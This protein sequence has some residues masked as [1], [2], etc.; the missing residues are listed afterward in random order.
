MKRIIHAANDSMQ[1]VPGSFSQD[2]VNDILD[3][4]CETLKGAYSRR[5]KNIGIDLDDYKYTDTKLEVDVSVYNNDILKLH[6]TFTFEPYSD[7]W[8]ISDYEQH[9]NTTINKFV[10]S[11]SRNA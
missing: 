4:L 9:L 11:L 7:Y 2:S 5:F 3:D 10:T 8:D 6:G 1:F